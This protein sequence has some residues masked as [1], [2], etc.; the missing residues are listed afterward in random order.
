MFNV[1][2]ISIYFS[3]FLLIFTKSVHFLPTY[4]LQGGAPALPAPL[5]SA[6]DF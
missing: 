2:V 3:T 1:A 5:R 4:F 6:P